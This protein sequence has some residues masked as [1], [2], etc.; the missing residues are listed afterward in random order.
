MKQKIFNREILQGSYEIEYN[1][2][3]KVCC[4]WFY[5]AAHLKILFGPNAVRL[6]FRTTEDNCHEAINLHVR[7]VQFQL[8]K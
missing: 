6:A 2:S 5:P 3:K 7:H 4:A 1:T 8:S